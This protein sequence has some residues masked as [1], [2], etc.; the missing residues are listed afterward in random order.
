MNTPLRL[1]FRHALHAV[2]TRLKLQLAENAVARHLGNHFFIA[3][4]LAFVGTHDL[5][6][7][8]T[9]FGIAAVHTEQIAGENRRF[10]TAGTGTHFQEAIA[11]II[12]IF[13]QQQHL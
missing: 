4:V 1:G 8:A 10:V 2:A 9:R 5:D 11:L 3:A 13:R 12:R 6:A 7:P